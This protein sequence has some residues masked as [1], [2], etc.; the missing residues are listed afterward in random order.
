IRLLVPSGRDTPLTATLMVLA[1]FVPAGIIYFFYHPI[2]E[3]AMR[4]RT[5][6][7]R[8]H[9]HARGGD[10]QHGR[11]SHAKPLSH[12]RFSADVICSRARLLPRHGT[13]RADRRP[14]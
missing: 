1:V 9:R 6:G 5:P 7:K 11:A 4:G 8:M 2:L 14:R 13:A 10:T 3:V 12:H